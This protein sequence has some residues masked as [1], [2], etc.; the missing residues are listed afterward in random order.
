LRDKRYITENYL[1]YMAK[2]TKKFRTKPSLKKIKNAF[3]LDGLK[4][5]EEVR[6]T[7]FSLVL[8]SIVRL[9][10]M[11]RMKRLKRHTAKKAIEIGIIE[12]R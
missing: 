2:E 7:S 1:K 5:Y 11:R 8:D 9:E 3:K 10:T 6:N 12:A 4:T